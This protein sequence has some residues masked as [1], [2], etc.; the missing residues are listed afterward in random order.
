VNAAFAI[1]H[2]LNGMKTSGSAPSY[3]DRLYP[4]GFKEPTMP[5]FRCRWGLHQWLTKPATHRPGTIVRRCQR[6]GHVVVRH[7]RPK[8]DRG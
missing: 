2:R 3:L 7:V 8:P 5:A 4:V 1:R 6:C